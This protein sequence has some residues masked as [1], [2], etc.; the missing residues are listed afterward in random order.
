M[1]DALNSIVEFLNMIIDS[2]VSAIEYGNVFTKFIVRGVQFLYSFIA[3]I[4]APLQSFAFLTVVLMVV[5]L[6]VGRS[7]NSG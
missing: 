1:V 3:F 7:N 2:V 5:M 6:F 4:P